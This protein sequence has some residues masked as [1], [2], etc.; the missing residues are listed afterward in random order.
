M[1]EMEREGK[2]RIPGSTG[3]ASSSGCRDELKIAPRSGT[4]GFDW[5][6]FIPMLLGT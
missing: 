4:G 1:I 2:G 6:K 3:M 5:L